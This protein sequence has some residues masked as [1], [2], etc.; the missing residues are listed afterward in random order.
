MTLEIA[1]VLGI[2]IISLILF[3]GEWLRMD[4]VALTVLASLVL[5]GLVTP[6]QAVEGFS[7]PAVI[8]V[9]A[10]FILS[11]GL[12]R[13]GIAEVIG[14]ALLRFAGRGEAR[15][16]FTIMMTSGVLSAFMNN[17]GVAALMLP[18]IVDVARRTRTS[19]S[20]PSCISAQQPSCFTSHPT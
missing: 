2:L 14:R 10:M 12:T 9:W 3:V 17:I 8:A 11:D 7:N 18:V 5:T 20:R 1:L 19:A 6:Q 16:A 15:M 13:T 4:V